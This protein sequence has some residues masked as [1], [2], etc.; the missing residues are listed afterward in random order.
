MD[1]VLQFWNSAQGIYDSFINKTMNG[2]LLTENEALTMAE[3]GH[4]LERYY[5][6]QRLIL[7]KDIIKWEPKDDDDYDGLTSART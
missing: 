6:L 7:N 1:N 2:E 5:Y 4:M 3:L